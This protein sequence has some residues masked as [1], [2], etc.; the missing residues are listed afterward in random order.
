[1]S[2]NE[3]KLKPQR[4]RDKSKEETKA[5]EKRQRRGVSVFQRQLHK[6]KEW[7]KQYSE[8]K[9]AKKRVERR[10]MR[11]YYRAMKDLHREQ[12]YYFGNSSTKHKNVWHPKN[13]EQRVK[14][15]PYDEKKSDWSWMD[16]TLDQF[17]SGIQNEDSQEALPETTTPSSRTSQREYGSAVNQQ[18]PGTQSKKWPPTKNQMAESET[19]SSNFTANKRSV[20]NAQLQGKAIR[21]MKRK[22]IEQRILAKQK[23]E[24]QL[25]QKIQQRNK[26]NKVFQMKTKNGQPKLFARMSLLL[27]EIH[28]Q[29]KKFQKPFTQNQSEIGREGDDHLEANEMH[30]DN[31]ENNDEHEQTENQ[32]NFLHNNNEEGDSN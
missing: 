12:K 21:E 6:R 19:S 30:D 8:E 18:R 7:V 22:E 11:G 13:M 26:R 10:V 4:K 3:Q 17:K 31:N 25:Q 15:Q 5:P 24:K 20:V 28:S 23:R 16:K 14:K 27:Q 29:E 32:W 2:D 9:L 1:M